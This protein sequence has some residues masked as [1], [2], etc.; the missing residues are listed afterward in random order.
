[1]FSVLI[2]GRATGRQCMGGLR[3]LCT[4]RL[5]LFVARPGVS[6]LRASLVTILE[7]QRHNAGQWTCKGCCACNSISAGKGTRPQQRAGKVNEHGG[8]SKPVTMLSSNP[9]HSGTAATGCD[10]S[11]CACC[12]DGCAQSLSHRVGCNPMGHICMTR[13]NRGTCKV[14]PITPIIVAGNLTSG[15]AGETSPTCRHQ[16]S[17]ALQGTSQAE[18]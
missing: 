9:S 5:S 11:A 16:T 8:S 12:M 17:G 15:P 3:M 2:E 6:A 4:A 7:Q 1:M 10:T 18:V 13:L 14:F